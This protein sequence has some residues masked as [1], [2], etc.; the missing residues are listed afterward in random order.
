MGWG[1]CLL[2]DHQ[3]YEMI[4]IMCCHIRLLGYMVQGDKS[5]LELELW[6]QDG[7]DRVERRNAL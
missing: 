6:G 2:E 5:P 7:E 4:G 3:C 1:D